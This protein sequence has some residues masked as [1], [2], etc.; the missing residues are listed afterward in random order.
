MP[1]NL[2]VGAYMDK[3]ELSEKLI[4]V[5]YQLSQECQVNEA[6]A[7]CFKPGHVLLSQL[8]NRSSLNYLK[9]QNNK[10]SLFLPF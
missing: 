1:N 3:G 8:V 4:S 5:E 6:L 7:F 10:R 2:S 9:N